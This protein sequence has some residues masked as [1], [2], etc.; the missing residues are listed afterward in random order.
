MRIKKSASVLLSLAVFLI[1]SLNIRAAEQLSAASKNPQLY[2]EVDVVPMPKQIKLSGKNLSL[3]TA[4]TI[5]LGRDKS[6][7][8]EIG[9]E[10]IQDEVHVHGGLV[11]IISETVSPFGWNLIV[12]TCEDNPLIKEAVSTKIVN[13]GKNNPGERGYEIR[14]DEKN[15]CIYMA[16]ADS[17]GALY[18]CVTFAEMFKGHG[19]E[20]YWQMCEVRDWP[21]NIY[22]GP[23]FQMGGWRYGDIN[24]LISSRQKSPENRE[25]FIQAM[26]SYMDRLLRHKITVLQYN[27]R[28]N[29]PGGENFKE[30]R[31]RETFGD[32]PVRETIRY[33]KERGISAY[34]SGA[35]PFVA[36][37]I[38]YPK[39]D[40]DTL[41]DYSGGWIRCWGLDEMRRK[42]AEN[43]AKFYNFFGFDFVTSHDTDTGDYFDPAQWSLRGKEDRER[44]GDDYTAAL[45]NKVNIYADAFKK[46]APDTTL[47]FCLIPYNYSILDKEAGEKWLENEF[48]ISSRIP[49]LAEELREKW[50]GHF[51][52]LNEN[53]RDNSIL[54][55]RETTADVTDAARNVMPDRGWYN[56]VAMDCWWPVFTPAAAKITNFC[57]PKD[58]IF[59]SYSDYYVP[60]QSLAVREYSWNTET[61]GAGTYPYTNGFTPEATKSFLREADINTPLYKVVLPHLARNLFG[62]QLAPYITEAVSPKMFWKYAYG[63]T[64]FDS[65]NKQIE[66][67]LPGKY[68][69]M[70]Q[71]AEVA[72]RGAEILD[73]GWEKLVSDPKHLHLPQHALRQYMYLREIYH[74]CS[75][76]YRI[77]EKIALAEKIAI[78]ERDVK[79]AES[80][81]E[82]ALA[83][84]PEAEADM[85]KLVSRRIPDPVFDAYKN[86]RHTD[87]R[88]K[89][90]PYNIWYLMMA[91]HA[92]FDPFREQI[93]S[94]RKSLT[95]LAT[96]RTSLIPDNVR[97]RIVNNRTVYIRETQNKV[98]IDGIMNEKVWQDAYPVE[99]FNI[100][101]MDMNLAQAQTR[102]YAAYDTENLYF[103]FQCR[104]PQG[105]TLQADDTVEILLR[106]FGIDNNYVH[107]QL[108]FKGEIIHKY[109]QLRKNKD[110][111]VQRIPDNNWR[112]QDMESAS[113]KVDD[114]Q[115]TMEVKIPLSAIG[116]SLN[117][118]TIN[119]C[120]NCTVD[121]K[122]ELSSIILFQENGNPVHSWDA[123][124]SLK[125]L[126][127]D[128]KYRPQYSVN[129]FN[130]WRQEEVLPDATATVAHFKLNIKCSTVMYDVTVYGESYGH[131]GRMNRRRELVKLPFVM[132]NWDSP[133]EYTLAFKSPI[134]QGGIRIIVDFEEGGIERIFRLGGWEGTKEFADIYGEGKFGRA[135]NGP[136]MFP[137][138][139]EEQKEGTGGTRYIYE[140]GRGTIEMWVNAMWLD[141]DSDYLPGLFRSPGFNTN[142]S[143]NVLLNCGASTWDKRFGVTHTPFL[144]AFSPG[145]SGSF[146]WNSYVGTSYGWSCYAREGI[147][148][149]S[150]TWHHW[151]FVWDE[152]AENI[153][154]GLR[155][156]LNGKE[157]GRGQ[158]HHPERMTNPGVDI[159]I[160]IGYPFQIN[161]R[162][163]SI[164]EGNASIDELRISRI[165]RYNKDFTPPSAPFALD[166]DTTALFHFDGEMSGEGMDKDNSTYTIKATPGIVTIK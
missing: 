145:S 75:W 51:R 72:A 6:C 154:N 81:L 143:A 86:E 11:P 149:V 131:D 31:W 160:G 79:K 117:R 63:Y 99:S 52:R 130:F 126:K 164:C 57:G 29:S 132:Y 68:G 69:L 62:D 16:G 56:W 84:I 55:L 78:E 106:S 151:A 18:A 19:N 103:A 141:K 158:A 114:R 24:W 17:M 42:T 73:R 142:V 10:W 64:R 23:S 45:I 110:G 8:S 66:D 107:F 76:A 20:A 102:A 47:L 161:C 49:K 153:E 94:A 124:R 166:K 22:M 67:S 46:F 32:D 12:G 60:L 7:Q 13:V 156:Y 147:R 83:L 85:D 138:I 96:S 135:V 104:V 15:N 21:D 48:G 140:S 134:E 119:L 58:I 155:I 30:E 89:N 123:F 152:T 159:P 127:E 95:R 54:A 112:C 148:N 3:N 157:I 150:G 108:P 92:S 38:H 128:E 59:P 100:N 116:N 65:I 82:E 91:S 122:P 53:L 165:P 70:K 137:S 28:V 87:P 162:N 37:R 90:Q 5:V 139:L 41:P 163:T 61:P 120:R 27:I 80:L 109:N 136:C 14:I 88:H 4:F 26:E 121:G 40:Y 93:Q 44:W 118:V 39:V 144:F 25:Q 129:M 43:A 125:P 101:N 34:T 77:K 74:V 50:T 97:P 115:Y 35:R 146:R 71:Q 1:M 36:L 2:Q 98:E 111:A 133:E 33:G 105:D 113:K 9:A